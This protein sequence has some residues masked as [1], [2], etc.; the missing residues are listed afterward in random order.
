[1]NLADPDDV[2]RTGTG[3]FIFPFQTIE[4]VIPFDGRTLGVLNDNNY[5]FS[6]GR[7]PGQPDDDEF[8]VIRTSGDAIAWQRSCRRNM[9][10]EPRAARGRIQRGS[11]TPQA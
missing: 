10:R 11:R 8:I 2:G 9:E 1:L 4:S 5:P 6:S 3:V 7:T